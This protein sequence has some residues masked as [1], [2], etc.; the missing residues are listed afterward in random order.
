MAA[1]PLWSPQQQSWLQAMGHAVY[2][3]GSA[4]AHPL[5]SSTPAAAAPATVATD[6]ARVARSPGRASSP[7]PTPEFAP[8]PPVA[9]AAPVVEAVARPAR[10]ELP[11]TPQGAPARRPRRRRYAPERK[12]C[13]P[14]G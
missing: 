12:A 4:L 14:R 2:L 10:R 5:E 3:H 11:E 9:S 8:A 6:A 13:C 1:A 7:P